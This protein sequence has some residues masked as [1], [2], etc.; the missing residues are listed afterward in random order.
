MRNSTVSMIMNASRMFTF[1]T[2]WLSRFGL[3]TSGGLSAGGLSSG[4]GVIGGGRAS[5]FSVPFM[6][7]S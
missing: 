5:I 1:S 6:Y 2:A 7:S 4:L 3:E